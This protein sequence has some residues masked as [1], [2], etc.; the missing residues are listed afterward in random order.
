MDHSH[1]SHKEGWLYWVPEKKSKVK[2]E[3]RAAAVLG[4][5]KWSEVWREQHSERRGFVEHERE[6]E[7]AR[8]T[9]RE[10]ERE[11]GRGRKTRREAQWD[12]QMEEK[13]VA[14]E[15]GGGGETKRV[16][17][18]SVRAMCSGRSYLSLLLPTEVLHSHVYNLFFSLSA[19]VSFY[20]NE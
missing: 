10:S 1:F 13:H 17:W 16:D 6:G 19:S 9:V 12:R 5:E 15:R 7:R 20:K 2:N 3:G 14:A 18:G 8:V 4:G 11:R